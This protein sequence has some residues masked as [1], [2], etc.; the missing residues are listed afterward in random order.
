MLFKNYLFHTVYGRGL[1]AGLAETAPTPY[2]VVTMRELWHSL[3]DE[4]GGADLAYVHFVESLELNRLEELV[5]ALPKAS[6]VIGVGGGRAI[7]VAKFIAWRRNIPL[8]QVPTITST[9]AAF[10]HRC[11]VRIKGVVRYIG[12]AVP[13]VVYVDYDLV[14]SAPPYLN[15]AGVGDVFCIHTALYDWKLA[16]E[17]GKEK[18]W[19]WDEEL[20]AEAR[21]VLQSVGEK[22][23][24]IHK[25]SDVGV[26][27][28]MEAHRWT[29]ASYHNSGWNPR[30]IEG[31]EHFFFYALE[32]LTGKAFIHGEPVCLGIIFMSLLQDNDPEGIWRSIEEVGVRLRPEEMN[33]TWTD[34]VNALKNTRKYAE[35]NKLF[36]TTVNERYITDAMV[37]KVRERLYGK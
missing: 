10:T 27:T 24:E 36:Y 28:L 9:N 19:P 8:F 11:A 31:C 34:V 29:G 35:E 33:I 17:R 18:L 6:S 5:K 1:I 30:H 3:K 2:I 16:T 20:A 25:V 21:K 37:E 26:K 12:W 23:Y 22:T 32:Y 7:D 15:H 14:R 4:L 13:E